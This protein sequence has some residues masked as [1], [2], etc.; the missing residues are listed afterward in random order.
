MANQREFSALIVE[1]EKVSSSLL[2]Y[3]LADHFPHIRVTGIAGSLQEARAL[4]QSHPIDLLFLDIE[5]PDG[6][7]FDLISTMPEV[8]FEVIVT[9]SY[10]KYMLDAIRHSAL[11]FIVKPV[12]LAD[13][14][15]ALARFMKKCESFKPPIHE[16]SSHSPHCR[17]LPL[18][19]QEGYVFID[20]ENIVHA[21]ASGAYSVFYL[22]NRNQ[23]LVSK[24]MGNFEERLLNHDFMRVH[25]S[26][27]INLGQIVKY[28]RGDGGYV[29]MTN[30]KSIPVSRQK[31]DEF[32]NAIGSL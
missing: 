11:D 23:V 5:L 8:H 28:V 32:L 6:K 20:F 22:V 26:H 10:S 29:V 17:K 31:K 3:L 2:N 30:E 19:T 27:I 1:D 15:N 7:G 18:P 21:E 13:L 24:P 14:G 25:K 12:T 9:T 4:I 16:R